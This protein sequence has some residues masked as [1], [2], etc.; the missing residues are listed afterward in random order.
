MRDRNANASNPRSSAWRAGAARTIAACFVISAGAPPAHADEPVT[1]NCHEKRLV[2]QAE[3]DMD[4]SVPKSSDAAWKITER[5][6]TQ[7]VDYDNGGTTNDPRVAA[8]IVTKID[9]KTLE[10]SVT[11]VRRYKSGSSHV[12]SVFSKGK[13]RVE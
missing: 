12:V 1:Y 4:Y 6:A 5:D 8:V 13:C 3:F 9:L 7:V 11:G 2:D 10:I